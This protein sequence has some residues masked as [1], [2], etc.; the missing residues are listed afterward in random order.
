MSTLKRA[1]E[2]ATEAH[3]DQLDKNNDTYLLHILRV[4]N[5]G[6][7]VNEKIAGVLHDLIEDTQLFAQA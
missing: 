1:I 5:A 3:K 2:I 7:T 6:R 4:M